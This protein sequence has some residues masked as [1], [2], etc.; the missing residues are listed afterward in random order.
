MVGGGGAWK[1]GDGTGRLHEGSRSYEARQVCAYRYI[2]ND[3]GYEYI[4]NNHVG[5]SRWKAGEGGVVGGKGCGTKRS[6]HKSAM[7][8]RA[9]RRNVG[10][11]STTHRASTLAFEAPVPVMDRLCSPYFC[12][13]VLRFS[14]SFWIERMRRLTSLGM[15][16]GLSLELELLFDDEKCLL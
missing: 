9:Q 14:R 5:R 12:V 4:T 2:C 3:G 1:A 7:D 13:A 15:G 11:D 10:R 6:F 8:G 16:A